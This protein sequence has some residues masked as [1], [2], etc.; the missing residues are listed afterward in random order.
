MSCRLPAL[1]AVLVVI[2]VSA[3]ASPERAHAQTAEAT[4]ASLRLPL[5]AGTSWKV[6]QGYNGG[7]HVPGP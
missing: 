4:L 1:A 6:I 3:A 5:P 2:L 7:T